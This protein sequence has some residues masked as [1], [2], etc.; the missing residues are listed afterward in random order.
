[1]HLSTSKAERTPGTVHSTVTM[2]P[3]SYRPLPIGLAFLKP[4]CL[5]LMYDHFFQGGRKEERQRNGKCRTWHLSQPV[6]EKSL[7][8]VSSIS[9][10]SHFLWGIPF[11]VR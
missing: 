10:V 4:K 9:Y 5:G 7:S 3:D 2:G 6:E 8:Q 11:I 1:M